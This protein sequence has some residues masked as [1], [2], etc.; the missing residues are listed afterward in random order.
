MIL[1]RVA[2]GQAQTKTG[3]VDGAL[4]TFSN[5]MSLFP[6]N[7]PL[8]VRYAETLMHAGR[9]DMAHHVLLDLFNVVPPTLDQ[10]RLTALAANSAGDVADA[11]YYMS[12]YHIA[13]GDL[14][15]AASQLQMALSVPKLSQIQRARFQAR[16][17]QIREVLPKG[18]RIN[19]EAPLPSPEP[20]QAPDSRS[21]GSSQSGSG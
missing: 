21:H 7:I 14:A 8:T 13:G 20:P 1:Y 4:E 17:D 3:D 9:A 2:L 12:E 11:Y 10:I 15:L 18:Q 19:F 6:R 16:L 5:A